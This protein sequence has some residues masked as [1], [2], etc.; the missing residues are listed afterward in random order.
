MYSFFLLHSY[1]VASLFDR[2]LVFQ[3]CSNNK[4]FLTAAAAVAAAVT[5]DLVVKMIIVQTPIS[6][7]RRIKIIVGEQNIYNM[8]FVC[9]KFKY[10][11]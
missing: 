10:T 1:L 9:A 4:Q 11:H 2:N 8:D 6:I 3:K 5:F 7:Y